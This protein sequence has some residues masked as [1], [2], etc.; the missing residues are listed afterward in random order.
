MKKIEKILLQYPE[1]LFNLQFF[2]PYLKKE[3]AH[4]YAGI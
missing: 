4:S 3:S 2:N 1:P